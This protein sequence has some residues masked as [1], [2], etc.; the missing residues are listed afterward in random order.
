VHYCH[1]ISVAKQQILSDATV[2]YNNGNRVFLCDLC[3]DIIYKRQ[4][5]MLVEFC[6]GGCEERISACEDEESP[7]LEATARD[8]LVKI[9]YT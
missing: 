9:Q 5:Q 4:S 3:Q 6:M 2:D 8:W 1:F 7:L